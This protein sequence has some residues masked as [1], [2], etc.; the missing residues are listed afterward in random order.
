MNGH[1]TSN[2][3][4]LE[5]PTEYDPMKHPSKTTLCTG[6][7]VL[8]LVSIS[9]ALATG[10]LG[11]RVPLAAVEDPSPIYRVEDIVHGLRLDVLGSQFSGEL[12]FVLTPYVPRGDDLDDLT[13]P[14][15]VSSAIVTIDEGGIL[16]EFD[17]AAAGGAFVVAVPSSFILGRGSRTVTIEARGTAS[18]P[19]ETTWT[20][21]LGL[22]F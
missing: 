22:G 1:T 19:P 16:R 2:P 10:M 4:G 6:L 18:N 5:L 9:T 11:L 20:E 7:A 12:V 15:T 8:S 3:H 14:F 17:L 13:N 21:S